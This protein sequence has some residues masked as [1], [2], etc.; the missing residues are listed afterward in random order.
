M[1][2]ISNSLTTM[3]GILRSLAMA[4]TL[5]LASCK[6]YYIPLENFKEQF[7]G[8]DSSRLKPVIIVGSGT[9]Y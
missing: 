5:L 3:S 6:T 4:V 2:L 9:I 1:T 7:S 8:I